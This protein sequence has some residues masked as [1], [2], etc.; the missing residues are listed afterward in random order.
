MHLAS[1]PAGPLQA[2]AFL[3]APQDMINL[4]NASSIQEVGMCVGV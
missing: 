2:A 4:S 1:K 3:A